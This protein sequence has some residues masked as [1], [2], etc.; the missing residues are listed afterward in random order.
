M[1]WDDFEVLGK[2]GRSRGTASKV[3]FGSGKK[4]TRVGRVREETVVSN[5]GLVVGGL[6]VLA[7]GAAWIWRGR[8]ARG[9]GL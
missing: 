1:D 4:E 9:L 6:G 2:E 3:V 7:V 8:V 5:A